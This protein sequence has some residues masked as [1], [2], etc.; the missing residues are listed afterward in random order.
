[1]KWIVIIASLIILFI[2]S[3]IL[4]SFA[5]FFKPMQLEFGITS[6]LLTNVFVASVIVVVLLFFGVRRIIYNFGIWLAVTLSPKT[7]PVALRVFL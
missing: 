6:L 7:R 3:G 4:S 2:I 1:M 5:V